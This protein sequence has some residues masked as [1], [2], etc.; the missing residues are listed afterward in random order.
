V[1]IAALQPQKTH[2]LPPSGSADQPVCRYAAP[3]VY[4]Q[5][6]IQLKR[7]VARQMQFG[8]K[9][10]VRDVAQHHSEEGLDQIHPHQD[11]DAGGIIQDH[12]NRL[13]FCRHRRRAG[14]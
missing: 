9:K 2:L 3:E 5:A 10:E 12:I 7:P 13:G 6:P 1:K 4:D 8:G 11:L 14:M